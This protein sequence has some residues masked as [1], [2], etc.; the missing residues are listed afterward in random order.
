MRCEL[1]GRSTEQIEPFVVAGLDSQGKVIKKRTMT[2]NVCKE[3][4]ESLKGQLDTIV[5]TL[6]K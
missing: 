5:K 2:K 3:C 6:S 1:C 4:A